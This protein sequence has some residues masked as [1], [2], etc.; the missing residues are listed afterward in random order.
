[1]VQSLSQKAR[2]LDP[3]KSLKE[4][5]AALKS[6]IEDLNFQLESFH[7][8]KWKLQKTGKHK[9]TRKAYLRV[10]IPDVHGAHMDQPA[11]SAMLADLEALKPREIV[12]LGDQ[13][14]CGGFL[15]EKHVW[16]YV[17][18]MGYTFA[19][20]VNAFNQLCDKVQEVCPGAQHH[21]LE[22]NHDHRIE[23]WCT[24]KSLR[25][26]ADAK[27]L[28]SL[29]SPSVVLN[30]EKRGI[31]YYSLNAF[32]MGLPIRGTIKLGHCH[33]TH[34]TRHGRHA[35]SDILKD[36]GGSCVHGDTHRRQEDS[37][38]TVAAGHIGCWCP[39]FLGKIQP[40]WM[41]KNPTGWSHGYHLQSVEPDGSFLPINVPIINGRSY[42][43]SLRSL[44]GL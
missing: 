12:W 41:R 33:F 34:G 6:Q 22:G 17:A 15:A 28:F 30:L 7:R 3:L 8:T 16:G 44:M 39:G 38:Q 26:A 10:A 42:L 29:F 11:V 31:P 37:A 18:E 4:E 1:M 20:D 5:N 40:Y 2:K 35:T 24:T 19:D 14:D 32:H 25:T 13:L 43:A 23:Q 27:L 9:P 36:F 21:M